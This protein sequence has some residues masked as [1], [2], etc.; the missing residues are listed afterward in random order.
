[1]HRI[2]KLTSGLLILAKSSDI[3]KKFHDLVDVEKTYLAR[4]HGDFPHEDVYE[5]DRTIYC[6]S[7]KEV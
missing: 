6:I 4:V 2:D 7:R 1:M 5:C 3:S